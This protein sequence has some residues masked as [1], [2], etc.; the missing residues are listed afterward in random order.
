MLFAD[1]GYTAVYIYLEMNPIYDNLVLYYLQYSMR[2]RTL[3]G[4]QTRSRV[5]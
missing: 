4:I 5:N 1:G 2:R 3:H